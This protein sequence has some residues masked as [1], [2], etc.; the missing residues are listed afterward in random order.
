MVAWR[1]QFDRKFAVRTLVAGAVLT[2]AACGQPG[3]TPT[4]DAPPPPPAADIMGAPSVAPTAQPPAPPPP[5]PAAPTVSTAAAA[6]DGSAVLAMAPIPDPPAKGRAPKTHVLAAVEPKPAVAPTSAKADAAPAKPRVHAVYQ[7]AHLSTARPEEAAPAMAPIPDNARA[8][9]RVKASAPQSAAV[10]TAAVKPTPKAQPTKVAAVAPKPVTASVA[11]TQPSI[12]AK[13]LAAAKLK[14][15]Q[16]K[17]LAAQAAAKA[18]AKADADAKLKAEQDKALAAQAAAKAKA[19][20]DAKALAAKVKAAQDKAKAEKEQLAAKAVATGAAV[21]A[22]TTVISPPTAP[23]PAPTDDRQAK[24]A[25]LQSA[26]T[27][28]VA[29]VA[30]L[31]AP[32]RFT[33]N[34]DA[35]VSLVLP[36]NFAEIVRKEAGKQ[37]LS[38][39]AASVNLNAVLSGD[40]FAVHPEEPASLPLKVGQPTEFHWTVSAQPG[41]KGLHADLGAELAGAGAEKI[42]LG[43]IQ[44]SAGGLKLTTRVL[45]IALLVLIAA[46]VVAWLAR[47]RS[48]PSRSAAARKQSR[49]AVQG[50]ETAN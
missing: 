11:K 24:V 13:A 19:N 32:S 30:V 48:S 47:G 6:M 43:A 42:S 37:G 15:E 33:P 39:A 9:V 20:S 17:A 34:Q 10:Q 23:T 31:K 22:T 46:L 40:G 14:A 28:Q 25:A 36:A 27:Q 21:A 41:A 12:D 45:A 5:P 49:L 8:G 16:D 18:K 2:L 29:K 50:A 44:R 35:D 3:P 26:L 38:D 1:L 4:H 7:T